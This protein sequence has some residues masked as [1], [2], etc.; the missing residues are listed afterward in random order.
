MTKSPEERFKAQQ[1]KEFLIYQIVE[2]ARR[3]NVELS[4]VERKMLYF[5]ET[6]ETLPN[7]LEVNDQFEREN[8]ASAYEEKIS[9]LIR[10]AY[11]RSR[12]TPEGA[13]RWKRAVSDLH[14]EDHY[15]LVMVDKAIGNSSVEA[16][17]S[18]I[19]DQL[20]LLGTAIGVIVLVLAICFEYMA[21]D[22]K[23]L[24]P[25]WLVSWYPDSRDGR[26]FVKYGLIFGAIGIWFIIKLW[27]M[28]V[29]GDVLKGAYRIT[30]GRLSSAHSGRRSN[31]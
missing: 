26:I 16:N 29:L 28:G 5:T 9:D 15:L 17:S 20:A 30:L 23:G 27:K 4:E 12:E 7:I 18:S 24:I 11:K 25:K 21:L 10:N 31:R 8:D 13:N 19:R 3:E 22:A 6:E 2:E 14:K 1:A